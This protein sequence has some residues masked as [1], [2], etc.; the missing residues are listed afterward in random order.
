[1]AA[2]ERRVF[3][4][5]EV[6]LRGA[7]RAGFEVF[8]RQKWR[9]EIKVPSFLRPRGGRTEV[10]GGGPSSYTPCMCSIDLEPSRGAST[11]SWFQTH[12]FWSG[13]PN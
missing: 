7:N 13:E 12:R 11:E 4:G 3:E 6:T 9:R 10:Y 5:W 8:K 1:M 2:C